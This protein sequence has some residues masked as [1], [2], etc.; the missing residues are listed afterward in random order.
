MLKNRKR[1][2]ANDDVADCQDKTGYDDYDYVMLDQIYFPQWCN[3]LAA[4]HD[5]TVSHLQG[6]LC[7]DAVTKGVPLLNIH[8][9]WPNYYNGY[10]QCCKQVGEDS[11]E[12]LDPEDV[13]TEWE[14]YDELQQMWFDPTTDL[15][16]SDGCNCATCYLLNHE[17]E[18]HGSCMGVGEVKELYFKAGL[19][20]AEALVNH[21]IVVQSM[22]GSIV[23]V[24]QIVGLYNH[25]V[26]VICDPKAEYIPPSAVWTG[27]GPAPQ[28]DEVQVFLEIQ[29]CWDVEIDTFTVQ[30]ILDDDEGVLLSGHEQEGAAVS[31][32]VDHALVKKA[33]GGSAGGGVSVVHSLR[34][35][36][37]SLSTQYTQST[38]IDVAT[39]YGMNCTAAKPS[40]ITTPCENKY[41][42]VSNYN[43]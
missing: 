22:N 13:Q 24:S 38:V 19:E 29:S 33:K 2:Q 39:F 20:I 28:A 23:E 35:W 42:Y 4:G 27:E 25:T 43:T 31:L 15:V 1:F 34:D 9:L 3:A 26:N 11:V 10:P 21:S 16:N 17:W 8:G 40:S 7:T 6:S 36:R 41:V 30:Q 5:P 18:K 37:E 12:P 32:I 14:T